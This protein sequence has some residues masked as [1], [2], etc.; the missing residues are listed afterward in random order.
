[1]LQ[2]TQQ[3]GGQWAVTEAHFEERK[4]EDC[5]NWFKKKNLQSI[6]V[7]FFLFSKSKN[8]SFRIILYSLCQSFVWIQARRHI[9]GNWHSYAACIKYVVKCCTVASVKRLPWLQFSV[10]AIVWKPEKGFLWTRWLLVIHGDQTYWWSSG[11]LLCF[12]CLSQY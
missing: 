10:G 3:I 2:G 12:Y 1:M 9:S 7:V 6:S 8:Y 5:V 11:F 4:E